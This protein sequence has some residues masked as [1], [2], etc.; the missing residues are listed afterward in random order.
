LTKEVVDDGDVEKEK[1]KMVIGDENIPDG[2]IYKM[3]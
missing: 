3:F 2:M 1:W